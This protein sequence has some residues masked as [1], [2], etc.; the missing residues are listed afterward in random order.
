MNGI[1]NILKPPDMTS[2]DIVVYIR[3]L[4][5]EK[6]TGHAGTLDPAAAGV[7]PICIGKGTRLFDHLA[8]K[9]KIYL[10]E[11]TLG[12]ST[13]TQDQQGNAIRHSHTE[14]AERELAAALETFKGHISQIPPMYSAIKQGGSKLYQ[15]AR[16]GETVQR[17]PRQVWIHCL[18]I[19]RRTAPQSWLLRVEC[20]K[21]TYIR[22]LCSDIGETLGCGAHLSMLIRTKSGPFTLEQA[23]TLEELA[24]LHREGRTGE[25][26]IPLDRVLD[27]YDK[28]VLP[29]EYRSAML[30]GNTVSWEG[31]VE[32]QTLRI[33][34][35]E[36][37]LGIGSSEKGRLRIRTLLV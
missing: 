37:F 11:I 6:K 27:Q 10:A 1:I 22:T 33:Y 16:K 34:C 26:L 25:S 13:D 14:I 9:D 35:G 12:T 32:S 21:G 24:R 19:V 18:E 31:D 4:L 29:P 2:S 8:L 36:E 23:V 17:T 5:G 30:N 7:L 28:V 3:R 20:S 15:I